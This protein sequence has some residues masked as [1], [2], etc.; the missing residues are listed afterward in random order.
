MMLELP[1][2]EEELP[3]PSAGVF[4]CAES[5]EITPSFGDEKSTELPAAST[6]EV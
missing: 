1:E 4:F 5:Q 3:E 2:D 6:V